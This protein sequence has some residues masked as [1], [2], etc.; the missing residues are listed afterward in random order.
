MNAWREIFH[1]FSFIF[2][3]STLHIHLLRK[4]FIPFLSSST[5]HR[6]LF[7]L[8]LLSFWYNRRAFHKTFTKREQ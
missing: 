4:A 7:I 5:I 1:P 3:L 6:S 8:Y 2:L